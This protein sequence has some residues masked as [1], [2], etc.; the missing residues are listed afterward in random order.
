MPSSIG[1]LTFH[2]SGNYGAVLQA[3]GLFHAIR[4][5]GHDPVVVDYRP[6]AARAYVNQWG[7][8]TGAPVAAARKRWRFK[9][10]IAKQ[11]TLTPRQYLRPEDFDHT[12]PT[13]PIYICGSDQPWNITADRGFDRPF[14]LDFAL[15]QNARRVSYAPSF[16]KTTDLGQHRDQ[17]ARLLTSFDHLSVRDQP[18]ADLL[19]NLTG[20]DPAIVMDPTFLVDF[21]AVTQP[22]DL[23]EDY[24]LTYAGKFSNRH[25]QLVHDLARR[26][27]LAVVS[28]HQPFPGA[29]RNHRDAGVEQWLGLFKHARFICTNYFHGTAFA[30]KFRKDFLLFPRHGNESRMLDLIGRVGLTDRFVPPEA[31]A[32]P[33]SPECLAIDYSSVEP[34]LS[35]E[36]QRSCE[37]LRKSVS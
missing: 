14:F 21:E 27:N 13:F 12:P 3:Y 32:A 36:I 26:L 16:G 23:P 7:L 4:A 25:V 9:R 10:F 1:I 35:D 29:A 30:I 18:S 37:Y 20:L 24:L 15:R 34:R 8:R 28:V 2:Y 6:A 19:R 11:F 31:H 17:I 33:D 5:L 22:P